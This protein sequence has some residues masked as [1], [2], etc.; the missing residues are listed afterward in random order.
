[1][2]KVQFLLIFRQNLKQ[3]LSKLR[4]IY[5]NVSISFCSAL[6]PGL[7]LHGFGLMWGLTSFNSI[8]NLGFN[9]VDARQ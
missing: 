6:I 2:E 7:K 9:L 3:I 1:M 8:L 5:L 4:D